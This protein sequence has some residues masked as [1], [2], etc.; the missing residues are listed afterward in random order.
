MSPT[1]RSLL[2][3]LG[4]AVPV[5]VAGCGSTDEDDPD[6]DSSH[7]PTPTSTPH[8]VTAVSTPTPTTAVSTTDQSAMTVLPEPGN[9]WTLAETRRMAARML[10]AQTG[11]VGKYESPDGTRFRAVVL[12]RFPRHDPTYKAERWACIGW[13]VAVAYERFAFAAGTGTEQR[14][15][16]PETPP[17]MDRTAIPG[18]TDRSRDLLARSPILSAELVEENAVDCGQ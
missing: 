15:Y 3:A 12:E 8:G 17:H 16:T 2:R 4:A 14:N 1:R 5:A 13:D 11:I 6:E 10:G 7:A 18:S 9:G